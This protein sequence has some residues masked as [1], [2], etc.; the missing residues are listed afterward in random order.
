[1]PVPLH[2]RRLRERGFNPAALIAREFARETGAR[3][4]PRALLRLRDTP[5]QTGLGRAARRRNVEGAFACRPGVSL[6]AP[7]SSTPAGAIWLV[8]DVVT[9]RSTLDA[10]ARALRKAGAQ[11]IA[12]VCLARTR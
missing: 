9:T 6:G 2:P 7:G 8:D 1:M 3:L 10:S 11:Q 4:A 5:S 12:A